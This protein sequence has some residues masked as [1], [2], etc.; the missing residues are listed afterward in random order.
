MREIRRLFATQTG[1]WIGDMV[2]LSPALRAL[3]QAFPSADVALQVRPL[4]R[5]LME[6][7]PHVN[8]VVVW[9]KTDSER[10]SRG[11]LDWVKRLRREEYDAAIIWHPTSARSAALVWFAGIPVRVGHR[12][13]GRG[14]FLTRSLSDARVQRQARHAL[15]L[16]Q[17]RR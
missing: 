14:A 16:A 15:E 3:R 8:R 10:G 4:V 11:F 13:A 9:D 6:R 1:G 7:H 12:V 5:E 17:H 2:L